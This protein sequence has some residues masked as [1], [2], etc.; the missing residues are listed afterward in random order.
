MA[1]NLQFAEIA[2]RFV[3]HFYKLFQ[4]DRSQLHA[5]YHPEH[6]FL[7]FED[8]QHRGREAI[9]AKYT[10]LP[11]QTVNVVVT[12]IDPQPTLDGGILIMVIGQLKVDADQPH[13][14]SQ[15]FHLK[16]F[17]GAFVVVNDMFRLNVH[18]F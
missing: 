8:S 17:E 7:T 16:S 12:K 1:F 3:A 13:A 9:H 6:A 14:F 5:V 18:N 11:F 2:E 10:S 15:L 4:E